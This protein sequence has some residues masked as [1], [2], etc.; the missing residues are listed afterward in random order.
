LTIRIGNKGRGVARSIYVKIYSGD[1][2][3][4]TDAFPKIQIIKELAFNKIFDIPLQIFVNDRTTEEIPLYIDLT[5]ETN[6]ASINKL[7]I[8]IKK[9]DQMRS[10][11]KSI[12]E[13]QKDQFGQLTIGGG[14]SIDI[15]KNIPTTDVIRTNAIAVIFG[16]RDYA[17]SDIP[18]VEY[19]KRDAQLMREYLVKVLGYD[20][21]NILPQNPDELMS[22]GNMKSLLRQKLPSY[23]KPDGSSDVFIYYAG[24]GA[25]S[26]E[27]QQPFFVPY[28]CDPNF[29]SDDNAY[30]MSEF[31]T[32]IEKLNA[33]QKMV[34]I[35]A[36]FSGQS[37]DGKALVKNASPVLL[38]VNNPLFAIKNATVFQSSESNQVSNW[39]PEKKHGMFTYFFLKG[40]QGAADLNKDGKI[41]VGEMENYINDENNNL[42]YVSQREMQ[43]KQKAVVNGAK[44]AV[45]SNK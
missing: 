6:L 22:V 8:P 7:R 40:L 26:T 2:T 12:V 43:R 21:K 4:I 18:R 44:E 34:V 41:T 35:D 29:V 38:R 16:I 28:D 14:L 11:S 31:Y 5:E 30:K 13:G 9:S 19:A 1:N 24:H 23:L 32:D 37:G 45:L 33:K 36:C 25:P 10:I 17:S 42:P 27:T 3:Y 20:P 39:Y 15:E